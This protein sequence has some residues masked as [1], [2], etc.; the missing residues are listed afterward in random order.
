M[1]PAAREQ[2][3]GARGSLTR[4]RILAEAAGI[5]NRCGYHGTTLD[6]LARVLG[7]TK[8]ALYCQVRSEEELLFWQRLLGRLGSE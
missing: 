6:G 3:L 7:V 1:G 4:E 8:A 5:F 2:A